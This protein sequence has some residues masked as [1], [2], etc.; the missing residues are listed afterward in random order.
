MALPVRR[1]H[2]TSWAGGAV[3]LGVAFAAPVA[4]AI[5]QRVRQPSRLE[6]AEVRVASA[7]DVNF[8]PDTQLAVWRPRYEPIDMIIAIGLG[9]T[10]ITRYFRNIA[11]RMRP[12]LFS[13]CL[14]LDSC[15]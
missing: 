12:S 8:V 4:V 11:V 5:E 7:T 3:V 14:G 1:A 6:E 10:A 13:D 9:A 15:A 2:L